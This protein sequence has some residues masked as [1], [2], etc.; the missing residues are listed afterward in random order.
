MEVTQAIALV[1]SLLQQL[2]EL[3]G[4]AQ[5]ASGDR[6][7]AMLNAISELATRAQSAFSLVRSALEA[8]RKTLTDDEV[9]EL[10]ELDNEARTLLVAALGTASTYAKPA[11]KDEDAK[12]SKAEKTATSS[13]K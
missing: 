10:Q 9:A 11:A 2:M 4:S 6:L 3:S 8:G 13:K 7:A 5:S 1:L 12:G